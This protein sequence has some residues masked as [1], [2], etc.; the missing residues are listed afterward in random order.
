MDIVASPR[1]SLDGS[2]D[3]G[4][5]GKFGMCIELRRLA[6][7]WMEKRVDGSMG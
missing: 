7:A 3:I 2:G 4:S 1:P 5:D 6:V